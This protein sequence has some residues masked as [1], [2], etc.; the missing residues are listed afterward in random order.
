[1]RVLVCAR[2]CTLPW[3]AEAESVCAGLRTTRSAWTVK[4]KCDRDESRLRACEP[5]LRFFVPASVPRNAEHATRNMRNET[6]KMRHATCNAFR[7]SACGRRSAFVVPVSHASSMER[8]GTPSALLRR[9]MPHAA[10]CH[11]AVGAATLEEHREQVGHR[12]AL[13]RKQITRG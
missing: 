5:T 12:V 8:G 13:H 6:C 3:T 4:M 7:M 2:A 11:A 1:M 9:R 10:W